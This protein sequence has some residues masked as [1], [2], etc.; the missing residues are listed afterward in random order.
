MRKTMKWA[1][2]AAVLLAMLPACREE[3][4]DP[5]DALLG[6]WR[7]VSGSYANEIRDTAGNLIERNSGPDNDAAGMS[8]YVS[9]WTDGKVYMSGTENITYDYDNPIFLQVEADGSFTSGEVEYRN[10]FDFGTVT[11]SGLVQGGSMDMQVAYDSYVYEDECFYKETIYRKL[12]KV[13]Q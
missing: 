4:T 8:L 11:I 9:E 1:A 13:T 3:A 2:L 10:E 12:V 7:V 5:R 6:E